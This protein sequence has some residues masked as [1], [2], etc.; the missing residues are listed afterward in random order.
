MILGCNL[1]SADK[2]SAALS[3]ACIGC[4]RLP[5][6]MDDE[7]EKHPICEKCRDEKL[8]T[9]YLCGINCPANPGAWQLHG[10]FHKELRKQRKSQADG[11]ALHQRDRETAERQARIAAQ[12][13]DTYDEMLAEGLRYGSKEDIRR[14]A[15]TYREAIALRPDMPEAYYN[16]GA[17]LCNSGHYVEA[18]Q[19]YL[20]AKERNAV[21]SAPWARATAAAFEMLRLEQ[22][23]EVAKPEWWNDEELKALSAMIVRAAPNDGTAVFMRAYVL[24]GGN[25]A[26]EAGSTSAAELREAAEHF[27]RSAALSDAPTLKAEKAR[28]AGVC[29]SL[30]Q[31]R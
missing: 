25:G 26:W 22:C 1:V 2:G 31:A 20:E 12:T 17:A 8:P 15:R 28:L 10:A 6:D 29:R 18:A 9:T 13:G 7:R 24:C 27:D 21:D 14:E 19:R 3:L 30:A 11:G 4:F 5:S 16:L 23:A